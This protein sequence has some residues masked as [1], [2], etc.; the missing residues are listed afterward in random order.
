MLRE[1]IL[2]VNFE[3]IMTIRINFSKLRKNWEVSKL[4]DD[5]EILKLSIRSPMGS[6]SGRVINHQGNCLLSSWSIKTSR[7]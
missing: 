6:N 1:R 2:C 4:T 5:F 7:I 3:T